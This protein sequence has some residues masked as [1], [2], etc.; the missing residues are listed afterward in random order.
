MSI[1]H[2]SSIKYSKKATLSN[3]NPRFKAQRVPMP[4]GLSELLPVAM[5]IPFATMDAPHW[6]SALWKK[7]HRQLYF[8]YAFCK[9]A[10]NSKP[11]ALLLPVWEVELS[12]N[13]RFRN[14]NYCSS[15]AIV[16]GKS[17]FGIFFFYTGVVAE[18][19]FSEC[20]VI[21]CTLS[22]LALVEQT[23]KENLSS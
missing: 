11:P 23:S 12:L 3:Y 2:A 20:F 4:L 16:L 13:T 15:E 1:I 17:N 10:S 18:S 7:Q 21:T 9:L 8:F 14:A 19:P 5:V 22:C 6:L